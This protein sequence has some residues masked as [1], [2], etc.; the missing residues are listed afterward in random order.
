M[1]H[2]LP[3][4]LGLAFATTFGAGTSTASADE[5]DLM[6]AEGS[7]L[8]NRKIQC[9]T[10]DEKPVVYTWQGKAYSRVPGERD[11]HLFN[12]DGM[13]IRQC[14][15]VEDP[16]K[17]TGYRM[18]SREIM[19]Y[20]DP[21]TNEVLRTWTNPWTGAELTPIHVANDPVNMR[22]PSFGLDR[23]GNPMGASIKEINGTWLMPFEVPLFYTNVLG[24]DYQ[25]YVGGTY[26]ATEIFD[27]NGDME[28]LL[29]PD[30]DTAYPVVSWVRISQWLPWMEMGGRF[31][32]LYFNA[33]GKKLE[34]FD[35]LTDTMKAEIAA[36]YP[37]YTTPPPVD[38]TRP[39][40][41]SWTYMKKILDERGEAQQKEGGH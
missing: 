34:S 32:N 39:N 27:F 26:H 31:G 1:K 6:T 22:A 40:E 25:K 13:N 35:Q 24:G 30:L 8:A 3:L 14:T 33:M 2:A 15:T 7:V 28:E 5:I 16:E 18:V 37:E 9:S 36:N 38:D 29:D 12:L 19:L 17:G 41:T 4:S 20:L 21:R 23:A 10:V 11:K